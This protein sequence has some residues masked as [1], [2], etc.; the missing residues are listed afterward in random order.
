MVYIVLEVN[1]VSITNNN[2]NQ[3]FNKEKNLYNYTDT[4]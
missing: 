2:K 1:I 4:I 3:N